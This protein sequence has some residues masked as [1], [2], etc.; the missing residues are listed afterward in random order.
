[1]GTLT[2]S[3]I[4]DE[5]VSLPAVEEGSQRRGGDLHRIVKSA[6]PRRNP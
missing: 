3:G 6:W 1:M 4:I 5:I 2:K